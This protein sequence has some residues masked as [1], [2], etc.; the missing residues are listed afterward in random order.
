MCVL[1]HLLPKLGYILED[2]RAWLNRKVLLI[3]FTLYICL[4]QILRDNFDLPSVTDRHEI[5]Y[6]Y[7][8][9]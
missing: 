4:F 6:K 7:Y 1:S 5:C 9:I 8:N 3:N 2:S